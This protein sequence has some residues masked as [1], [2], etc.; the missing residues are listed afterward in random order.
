MRAH[1][2]TAFAREFAVRLA[3]VALLVRALIPIGWMPNPHGLEAGSPIILCTMY[4]PVPAVIGDDGKPARPAM[5]GKA[6]HSEF[7][8]LGV[9]SAH[10]VPVASLSLPSPDRTQVAIAVTTRAQSITVSLRHR[11]QSQRGPPALV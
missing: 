8:L 1:Y 2:I 5:P 11:P 9:A 7:C 3:L 6:P 4:G 10:G